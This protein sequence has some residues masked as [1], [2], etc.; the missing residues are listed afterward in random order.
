MPAN[1]RWDLIRGL[2]DQACRRRVLSAEVSI[3]FK[4]NH[5]DSILSGTRAVFPQ[6]RLHY[7]Q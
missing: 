5:V 1:S 3:H 6:V 7:R 2:K 4:T